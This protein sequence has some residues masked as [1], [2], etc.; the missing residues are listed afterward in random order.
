MPPVPVETKYHPSAVDL[1]LIKRLIS[2]SKEIYLHPFLQKEFISINKAHAER[3]I[4]T[5]FLLLW[6]PIKKLAFP[7]KNSKILDY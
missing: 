5:S 2:E 3:L 1:L 7:F 4:G 6:F